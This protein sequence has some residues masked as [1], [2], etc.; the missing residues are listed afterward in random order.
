M[1][2]FVCLTNL[3]TLYDTKHVFG[4]KIFSYCFKLFTQLYTIY[5]YQNYIYAPVV[6]IF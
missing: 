6:I 4:N 5:I 3:S 1:I 2:L